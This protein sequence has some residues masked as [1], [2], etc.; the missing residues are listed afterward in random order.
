MPE[1]ESVLKPWQSIGQ[2]KLYRLANSEFRGG[3]L[4]DPVGLGK[5]LTALIAA[6][7]VR[8][9]LLPSCGF[10]LV[11]CRKSCVYQW[12]DEVRQHFKK[13]SMSFPVYPGQ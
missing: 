10:I 1:L 5:S 11:I 2:E 7:R 4:A 8:K 9:A 13:V 12:Y 6:L 3:F